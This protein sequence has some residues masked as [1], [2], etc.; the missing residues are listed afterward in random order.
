MAELLDRL[1]AEFAARARAGERPSADEYAARHPELADRIRNLFPALLLLPPPPDDTAASGPTPPDTD[2]DRTGPY[3]PGTSAPAHPQRV[4][5]DRYHPAEVLNPRTAG[6]A[7]SPALV[8]GRYA[9]GGE[10]A[11]G[12]MGAVYRATDRAFDREVALKLLAE[13]LVGTA[14]AA[15]FLTEARITGQLQHPSIPPAHDLGTLPDGRPFLAMKL[16]RGKTLADRLK[17]RASTAADLNEFL[18]VFEQ[19]CLAVAYAHSRGVIHRDLKPANVMVGAFGE[20]Q[21]MDWGLAKTLDRAL[22]PAHAAGLDATIAHFAGVGR[23]DRPREGQ[24]PG[25][26]G[27]DETRMGTVMGTPSYMPP[28]QA[29]GDLARV[30]MRADVFSLGAILCVILTGRPPYIGATSQEVWKKAAAADLEDAHRR[31]TACTHAPKAVELARRCLHADP[32]HR[33]AHAGEVAVAVANARPG[34]AKPRRPVRDDDDDVDVESLL[35]RTTALRPADDAPGVGARLR[36]CLLSL[37]LIAVLLG[38]AA[39]FIFRW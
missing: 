30:D 13:N 17:E 24:A 11:R 32:A 25:G 33:P 29:N 18:G 1:A 36:G 3:A 38:A 22:P 28:E 20:V 26:V 39:W 8:A 14:A 37:V 15:R 35:A 21:V 16:I 2:P 6:V 27:P 4:P 7:G 10:I 34:A 12:G 19:V 9:L 31:L 5:E 23:D